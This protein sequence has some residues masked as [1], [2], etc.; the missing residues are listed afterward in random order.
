MQ[1]QSFTT[2]FSVPQSPDEVFA[3]INDPRAWWSEAIEGVTDR[4]GAQ[5]QYRYQ[6]VHR[7]SFRVTELLPGKKV[8]WHVDDNY[9]N[10][11]KN[12]QEWTGNDLVFEI[13]RRGDSTQVRFTQ[14]GLVPE[15]E[16]YDVCS[17]AWSSYVS[18]SL[19]NLITTGQGQPNPIEEVVER[20]RAQRGDDFTTSFTVDLS[21][22]EVFAAI[23]DVRAWWAGE[24]EGRTDALGAEFSYRYRDL[25][26]TTQRITEWVPGKK[27]VWHVIDSHLSFVSDEQEWRGTDIVFELEKKGRRTEVRFTHV[28]LVPVLACYADCSGAW[29]HYINDCLFR[30]IAERESAKAEAS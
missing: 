27:V 25:H 26:Q 8:V 24:I 1:T 29:S 11:V 10:F 15:Y 12:E 4:L 28:G 22:D 17:S 14:L 5:W 2:S 7:A 18:S 21:P 3:A 9:F 16:C 20:A 23:N 19:K 30:W 6:N 13:E